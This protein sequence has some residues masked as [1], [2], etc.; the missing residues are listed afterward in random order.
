[1]CK[2]DLVV[3][4]LCIW[5]RIRSNYLQ[6]PS[7][8]WN[9]GCAPNI[10]CIVLTGST[11][12][13]VH[14]VI[15]KGDTICLLENV[16]MSLLAINVINGMTYV[17]NKTSFYMSCHFTLLC[18][19]S[20]HRGKGRFSALGGIPHFCFNCNSD[21]SSCV[22]HFLYLCPHS[23]VIFTILGSAKS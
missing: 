1:M 12:N 5:S 13:T 7:E 14:I 15:V 22:L 21:W 23:A 8:W 11:N 18:N 16:K 19:M 10:M 2:A 9:F 17:N 4:R 3:Q 6:D 20:C